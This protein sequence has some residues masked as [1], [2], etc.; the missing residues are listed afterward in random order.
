MLH[1]AMSAN[2]RAIVNNALS[3]MSGATPT[4]MVQRAVYLIASSP[5]YFVQR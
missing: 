5:E 3:T 4:A 1:G 2:L